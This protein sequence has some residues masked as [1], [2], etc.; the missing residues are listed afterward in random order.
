MFFNKF[1]TKNLLKM[2]FKT[3]DFS[4]K[5][6]YNKKVVSPHLNLENIN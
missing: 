6:D 5:K 1:A 3:I 4:I 2:I